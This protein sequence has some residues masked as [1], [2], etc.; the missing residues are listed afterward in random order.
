MGIL[1]SKVTPVYMKQMA[2]APCSL[3]FQPFPTTPGATQVNNG[4]QLE[5]AITA[6]ISGDTIE[7]ASPGA[8]NL[9]TTPSINQN[10]LTITSVVAGAYLTGTRM[11]TGSPGPITFN[12]IDWRNGDAVRQFWCAGGTAITFNRCRFALAVNVLIGVDFTTGNPVGSFDACI[13]ESQFTQ[14]AIR[15]NV[16]GGVLTAKNCII[17]HSSGGV[18]FEQA[19]GSI[20]C[21]NCAVNASG[22]DYQGGCTGDYNAATDATAPGGNSLQNRV[23][24]N[25]FNANYEPV[26]ATSTLYTAGTFAQVPA[27]DY[28]GN[29]FP[30]PPCIGA[31]NCPV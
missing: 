11:Q 3:A 13:F 12:G 20:V 19:A 22:N 6:A 27:A 5:A 21:Y 23:W 8:Y 7:L 16:A 18:G 10:V 30:N 28:Y 15:C 24:G 2:G 31:I 29:T 4:A 9:T 25:E 17:N 26:L 1:R 14:S